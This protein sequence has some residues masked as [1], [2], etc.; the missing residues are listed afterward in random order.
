MLERK[1]TF[2]S[3]FKGY[4]TYPLFNNNQAACNFPSPELEVTWRKVAI[5]IRVVLLSPHL[6]IRCVFLSSI[7]Y[8]KSRR[9]YVNQRHQ[10]IHVRARLPLGAVKNYPFAASIRGS[11]ASKPHAWENN[12]LLFIL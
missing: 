1:R 8:N 4:E 11:T 9:V 7:H 12:D 2:E 10:Y 6:C 5:I 3:L